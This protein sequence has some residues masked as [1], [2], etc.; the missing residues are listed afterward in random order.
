MVIPHVHATE[1]Q[2]VCF[3]CKAKE[4]EPARD[5]MPTPVVLNQIA[6]PTKLK[7]YPW[8]LPEAFVNNV[9]WTIKGNHVQY[10]VGA[11]VILH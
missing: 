5:S 9:Q 8:E 3:V 10:K 7:G 4:H 6:E 1:P 11:L 2:K